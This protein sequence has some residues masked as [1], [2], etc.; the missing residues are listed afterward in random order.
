[1][2]RWHG[3]ARKAIISIRATEIAKNERANVSN[4]PRRRG[5]LMI[6]GAIALL[7]GVSIVVGLPDL[8]FVVLNYRQ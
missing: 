1:V 4:G 2:R 6:A 8:D 5:A 3:P 7:I